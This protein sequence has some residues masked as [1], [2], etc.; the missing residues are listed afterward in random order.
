M[1]NGAD[2]NYVRLC[3]AL[4]GFK[5]RHGHWPIRV[6]VPPAILDNL[7]ERVFDP[8]GFADV[9]KKVDLVVGEGFRAEDDS[10]RMFHYGREA[11]PERPPV[12]AAREWLGVKIRPDAEGGE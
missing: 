12:P 3:A 11:S 9:L 2:K 5:A 7:R 4:D 10:G 8:A 1:P 6:V